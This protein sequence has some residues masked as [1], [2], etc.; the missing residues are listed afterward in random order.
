M[1]MDMVKELEDLICW[2][3]N[4]F[5]DYYLTLRES[6]ERDIW[7]S[8]L[9]MHLV[10]VNYALTAAKLVQSGSFKAKAL[11]DEAQAFIKSTYADFFELLPEQ[12]FMGRSG[13]TP[14]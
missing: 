3:E 9:E 11:N 5:V 12:A 6:S 2:F 4:E 1:K 14:K 13:M 7:E 10:S 8:L